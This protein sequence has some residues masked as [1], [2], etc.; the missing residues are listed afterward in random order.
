MNLI[1]WIKHQLNVRDLNKIKNQHLVGLA[2]A[3]FGLNMGGIVLNDR[4]HLNLHKSKIKI[5]I[6]I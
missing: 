4:C 1:W 3:V 5:Q 2:E 6:L